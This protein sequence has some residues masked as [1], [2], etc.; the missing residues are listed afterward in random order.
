MCRPSQ[1]SPSAAAADP[2]ALVT[3]LGLLSVAP[4]VQLRVRVGQ[5]VQLAAGLV[6]FPKVGMMSMM[7]QLQY[8]AVLHHQ[9]G[10]GLMLKRYRMVDFRYNPCFSFQL[11]LPT[12]TSNDLCTL[13]TRIYVKMVRTEQC[14]C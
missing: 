4:D 1:R 13:L 10:T 11:L 2:A 3:L 14:T 9:R 12:Q 7:E 5:L 8:N 6:Q